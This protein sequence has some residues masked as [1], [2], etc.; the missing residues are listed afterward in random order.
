MFIEVGGGWHVNLSLVAKVHVLDQGGA[1]TVLK[2]Y[3][4]S[5]QHL[6]D[7]SPSAPDELQRILQVIQSFGNPGKNL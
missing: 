3:S 5:D 1:G 2:F 6:G 7:F 4:A